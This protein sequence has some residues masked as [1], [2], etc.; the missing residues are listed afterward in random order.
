MQTT[1]NPSQLAG[2]VVRQLRMF[3][4]DDHNPDAGVLEESVAT[5][6]RRLDQCF[7]RVRDKRFRR[8][9]ET[10]FDHLHSDQYAM[11]LYILGNQSWKD[12]VESRVLDKLYLLNKTLHALDVFYE[13]QLPGVFLFGHPVGSVLGR[14]SYGDY[15]VVAQNCTVGG[16]GGV[17]P[18]LGKGT[19][20]S[21]SVNIIGSTILEDDV[22]VG[23][24]ALLVNELVPARSTVV[25]RSPSIKFWPSVRASWK[26]FYFGETL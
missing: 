16:I 21:G 19:V 24:G 12:G 2:Y 22:Y 18:V 23:A 20:L 17:Y 25:G 1:L 13:V 11:F 9:G 4:P 6:L 26:E 14:A 15:L 7:S 3:F 5:S 10:V 8:G